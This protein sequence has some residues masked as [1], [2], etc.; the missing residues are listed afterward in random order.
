MEER[1]GCE[2]KKHFLCTETHFKREGIYKHFLSHEMETR[3]FGYRSPILQKGKD[4]FLTLSLSLSEGHRLVEG[5][6]GFSHLDSRVVMGKLLNKR[7]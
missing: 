3:W 1:E 6:Y 2:G 7:C 4:I 5:N